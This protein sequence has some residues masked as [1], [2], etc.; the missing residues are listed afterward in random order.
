MFF[1]NL[2]LKEFKQQL[3]SI[4]FYIFIAIALVFYFSQ[5][6]GSVNRLVPPKQNSVYS[7]TK[8]KTEDEKVVIGY[9]TLNALLL[10]EYTYRYIPI[11]KKVKLNDETLNEVK[12]FLDEISSNKDVLSIKRSDINIDYDTM[13]NF[14]DSLDE[15]L[16]GNTTL[17]E[18]YRSFF[19]EM[20]YEEACEEYEKLSNRSDITDGY[21]RL[22]SDYLG[23]V[24]AMF[25][26]FVCV[27]SADRDKRDGV[28]DLVYS[29]NVNSVA[30]VLAKAIGVIIS[31]MSVILFI[32]LAEC[33]VFLNESIKYNIPVNIL[34][35]L[36]YLIIWVGPTV[37][38]VVS[39]CMLIMML[40]QNSIIS[41]I[42]QVGMAFWCE[43]STQL[44]GDYGLSKFIIRFNS[45]GDIDIYNSCYK[46]IMYNRAFYFCISLIIIAL[47]AV[48]W[49]I[50]RDKVLGRHK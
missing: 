38:F 43:N 25:S 14:M 10:D 41:I 23:I 4:A 50:R 9:K 18:K 6:N 22:L 21:G 46:Y 1:L 7:V 35:L 16:G 30:Y 44:I 49:N 19:R 36:K 42:I 15:E 33:I 27:S 48:I 26:V 24:A 2:I 32:G 37:M 29:S 12:T 45:I 13:I 17:G 31:I 5:Y 28:E 11:S 20:T 39:L 34:P 40:I 8:A 3:K 47:S